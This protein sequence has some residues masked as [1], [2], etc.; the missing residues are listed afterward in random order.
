M[1]SNAERLLCSREIDFD[2]ILGKFWLFKFFFGSMGSIVTDV[3]SKG[4]NFLHLIP[5]IYSQTS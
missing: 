4:K 5:F 2:R 3:L 1:F